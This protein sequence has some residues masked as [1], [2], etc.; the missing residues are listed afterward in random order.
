[1]LNLPTDQVQH[2]G[3]SVHPVLERADTL[4][5]WVPRQQAFHADVL[6]QRFPVD[7]VAAAHETPVI[8][9]GFGAPDKARI[10]GEGYGDRPPVVQIDAQLIPGDPGA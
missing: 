5:R 3:P 9:L 8:P 6:V 2:L 7:A 10:P 1:M 4:A